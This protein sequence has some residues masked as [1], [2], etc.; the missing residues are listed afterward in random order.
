METTS[1]IPSAIIASRTAAKLVPSPKCQR[2]IALDGWEARN[3]PVL[4]RLA[5]LLIAVIERIE[6]ELGEKNVL[7]QLELVGYT[8][9][10]LSGSSDDGASVMINAEA[11]PCFPRK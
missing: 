2:E 4:S 1:A 9:G 3:R 10:K 8:R 7:P 5:G 6:R 11:A